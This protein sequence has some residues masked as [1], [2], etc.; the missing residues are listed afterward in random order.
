MM[1]TWAVDISYAIDKLTIKRL[2]RTIYPLFSSILIFLL[3]F[4]SPKHSRNKSPKN[5]KIRK[6]WLHCSLVSS[7]IKLVKWNIYA[8]VQG[9]SSWLLVAIFSYISP[10]VRVFLQFILYV[11]TTDPLSISR[12]LTCIIFWA[13]VYTFSFNN[14]NRSENNSQKIILVSTLM[15]LH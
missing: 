10:L 4:H 13:V 2:S 11:F 15:H 1:N 3:Y 5:E 8:I 7:Q 9:D 12:S 6:Y 14:E